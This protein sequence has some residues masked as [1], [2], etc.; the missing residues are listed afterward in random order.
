MSFFDDTS[1]FGKVLTIAGLIMAL[2]SLVSLIYAAVY[3]WGWDY[4]I[5]P[6]GTLIYGLMIAGVGRR[7]ISGE[8][9]QKI[10]MVG[11]FVAIVGAGFIVQGFFS[12]IG[13]AAVGAAGAGIGGFV[14]S[15][16]LGVIT[17]YIARS[18]V[19][20]K[21]TTMD[22]F[23]WI[24]LLVIFAVMF[25]LSLI[26]IF[27]GWGSIPGALDAIASL[28]LMLVYAF[29]IMML[30]SDDVKVEMGMA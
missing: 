12:M 10:D 28:F 25:I 30:L 21:V 19:D 15:L 8:I 11:S 6:V 14:I 20:G 2:A 29:L 22:R 26:G 27:S 3:D 13:A 23:L 4:I 1:N 24:L 16:I 17:I 7:V 9:S 5:V 18:V